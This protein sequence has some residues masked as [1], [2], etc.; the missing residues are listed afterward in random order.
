MK[1]RKQ[2]E[3][4]V[5]GWLPKE[6]HLPTMQMENKPKRFF[7][8]RNIVLISASIIIAMLLS[9]AVFF[10]AFVNLFPSSN[11]IG[12]AKNA[13]N[14]YINALN[15][16]NAS[17]AW[18][19]MSPDMQAQYVTIQNFTDSCVSQ[20]QQSGWHAQLL[21]TDFLYGTIAVYSLIPLQNSCQVAADI[22]I[23]RNNSA[24]TTQ[25][26]TFSLKTY[27]YDDFHSS[28]WK[29]DNRFTGA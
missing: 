16:Y 13:V 28:D 9:G 26:F 17:A 7:T 22:E 14:T 3:G 8:K 24:S 18:D 11:P 25:T 10:L 21:R 19:L 5:R 20:L 12:E 6:P 29:I 4:H 1:V 15:D 2:L 27:A 23:T